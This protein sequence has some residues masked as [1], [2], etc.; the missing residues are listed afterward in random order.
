MSR[1]LVVDRRGI[2]VHG[3]GMAWWAVVIVVVVSVLA[4]LAGG[5]ESMVWFLVA[6]AAGMTA[7][8]FTTR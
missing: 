1:P 4:F 5:L 2:Y 3:F 6:V 8:W 7:K